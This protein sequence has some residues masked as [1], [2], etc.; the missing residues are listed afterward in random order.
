MIAELYGG[1]WDGEVREVG[2]AP[3]STPRRPEPQRCLVLAGARGQIV[4]STHPSVAG[5]DVA[6]YL[7]AQV[8]DVYPA[9]AM[10][11]A[12]RAV[13]RFNRP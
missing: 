4:R 3:G 7:L 6:T 13:Y 2:L 11:A 12:G 9:W 10:N 1:P 5:Q 8:G